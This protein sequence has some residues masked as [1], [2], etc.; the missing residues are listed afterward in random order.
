MLQERKEGKV[1]QEHKVQL[2][3]KGLMALMALRVQQAHKEQQE[4]V[5]LTQAFR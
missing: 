4:L 5:A 1:L 2:A 3:H